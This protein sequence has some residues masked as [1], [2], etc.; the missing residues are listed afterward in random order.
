MCKC[1]GFVSCF[2]LW[3]GS[4]GNDPGLRI[5]SQQICSS[6]MTSTIF[7]FLFSMESRELP[8]LFCH[9]FFLLLVKCVFG[10]C[11]Q[12]VFCCGR[13]C[14]KLWILFCSL[15]FDVNFIIRLIYVKPTLVNDFFW[16]CDNLINLRLFPALLLPSKLLRKA[17]HFFGWS[18]VDQNGCQGLTH[19][20]DCVAV[21]FGWTDCL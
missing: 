10:I 4:A 17:N 9:S 2:S 3:W 12:F 20:A 7:L 13:R 8:L 5:I 6:N 21:T 16:A 14:G 11:C 15:I 19:V 18:W 1:I